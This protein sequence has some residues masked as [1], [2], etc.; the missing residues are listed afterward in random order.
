MIYNMSNFPTSVFHVVIWDIQIQY[1]QHRV[2]EMMMEIF[3]SKNGLRAR[4]NGGKRDLGRN[5]RATNRVHGIVGERCQF[6]GDVRSEEESMNKRKGGP[7]QL[8]FFNIF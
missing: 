6:G 5:L 8:K 7:W 2:L 4:M 3:C 1:V